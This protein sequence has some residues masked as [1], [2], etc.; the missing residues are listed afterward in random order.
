[1]GMILL[2]YVVIGMFMN[3]LPALVLT[4]PLFFPIAMKAGFAARRRSRRP[5]QNMASATKN[6]RQIWR[7]NFPPSDYGGCRPS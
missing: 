3:T 4:V 5:L 2:F 6:I 1:M 7:S